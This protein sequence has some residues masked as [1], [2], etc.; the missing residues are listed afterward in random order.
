MTEG[1]THVKITVIIHNTVQMSLYFCS[2]F[3]SYT[4]PAYPVQS[5]ICQAVARQMYTGTRC[6]YTQRHRA[7]IHAK[8]ICTH[9][10]THI[11]T[12]TQIHTH[13]YTHNTHTHT[14][15]T[16][17]Y[18]YTHTHTHTTY[19]YKYTQHTHLSIIKQRRTRTEIWD[20]SSE[21]GS[22]KLN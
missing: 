10:Y 18:T 9:K 6:T 14:T 22:L 20:R 13:R 15:Y 1:I 16:Y 17:T 21:T 11:H 5:Q 12:H 8:Y 4:R 7:H 3:P 19:T 2:T